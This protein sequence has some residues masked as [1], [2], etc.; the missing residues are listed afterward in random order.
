VR[1][2]HFHPSRI[3][4][5]EVSVQVGWKC[6]ECQKEKR[7]YGSLIRA[8]LESVSSFGKQKVFPID[9]PLEAKKFYQ[10]PLARRC[11]QG[12]IVHS[13]I[14]RGANFT[15][16]IINFFFNAKLILQSIDKLKTF[17]IFV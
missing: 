4:F 6:F 2:I 14:L 11:G 10:K 16:L 17:L 5:S 1:K 7:V 3:F 9:L 8:G 12:K 15:E 13:K